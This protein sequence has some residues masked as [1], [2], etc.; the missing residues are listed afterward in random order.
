MKGAPSHFQ[1][2][3]S[4]ILTGLIGFLCELYLDDLIIY[5]SSE[6]EFLTNLENVLERL[7]THRI[8]C[9]PDKCKFGVNRVEYVGHLI[10]TEGLSFSDSKKDQVLEF[11]LPVLI[12]ELHSFLGL[13]NYFGDHLRDLSTAL[14]S[15]RQLLQD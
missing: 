7:Q 2:E 4:S 5:G 9:N 10:D 12:K 3:V 1:R 13:V 8:T 15:L 6:E 14:A 11:P